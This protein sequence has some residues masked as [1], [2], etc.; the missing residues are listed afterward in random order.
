M[1]KDQTALQ[2]AAKSIRK[3]PLQG[4]YMAMDQRNKTKKE[5]QKAN[6]ALGYGD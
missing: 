1:L 2:A 4:H 3:D 6:Y 5:T